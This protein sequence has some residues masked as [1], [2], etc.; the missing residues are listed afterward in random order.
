VKPK[1]RVAFLGNSYFYFNDIPRLF[2]ALCGGESAVLVRDCLRGGASW[3]SLLRN[4]NGMEEK[5]STP[6]AKKAD[7]TYDIG[8][9]TVAELLASE[10]D[11]WHYVVMNTH[12][13][14]AAM[15]GRKGRSQGLAA[16]ELL[17]PMLQAAGARPVLLATPAYRAPAKGSELLGSWDDFRRKQAEGFQL[18]RERLADLLAPSDER[19]KTVPNFEVESTRGLPSL[20]D[21]NGAFALVRREREQLWQELFFDDHFHPSALGSYLAACIIYCAIFGQAPPKHLAVPEE[22]ASLFV[23]ARRMLPPPAVGPALFSKE[24]LYY[25][26]DVAERSC[27]A[28]GTAGHEMSA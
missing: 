19:M 17:A 11:G 7:G 18:Y 16:L 24:D 26:R 25:L 13:Q 12:S 2:Q 21:M 23:R 1:L 9:P 22:P 4:G 6:N 3:T 15:E 20:A 5:F 27:S 14:E 8:S 28:T 10:P